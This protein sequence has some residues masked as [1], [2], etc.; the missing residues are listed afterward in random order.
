MHSGATGTGQG[1]LER[2]QAPV[3]AFGSLL[4]LG[5]HRAS[6]Q[7]TSSSGCGLPGSSQPHTKHFP[8]EGGTLALIVGKGTWASLGPGFD[9]AGCW[10]VL[11]IMLGPLECSS[12]YPGWSH[13]LAN[14]CVQAA[15][16]VSCHGCGGLGGCVPVGGLGAP[17][18]TR[19]SNPSTGQ[20]FEELKGLCSGSF[21]G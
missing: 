19:S 4:T 6:G 18:Q 20:E 3:A 15:A 11:E 1:P 5:N 17:A 10:K 14:S 12:H 21:N 9:L 16:G 2:P 7:A 8:G 13:S